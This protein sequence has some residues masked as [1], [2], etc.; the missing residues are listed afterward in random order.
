MFPPKSYTC[1]KEGLVCEWRKVLAQSAR[2]LVEEVVKEPQSQRQSH[3]LF[4]CN[5]GNFPVLAPDILAEMRRMAAASIVLNPFL[6]EF[7]GARRFAS[8][9]QRH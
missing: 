7:T 2:C 5:L 4:H 3:F 6:T 1:V 8:S 9:Y